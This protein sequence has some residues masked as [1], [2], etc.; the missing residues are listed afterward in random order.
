[1]FIACI[2]IVIN[3]PIRRLYFEHEIKM[4]AAS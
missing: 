1:M 4:A 3:A 2:Y